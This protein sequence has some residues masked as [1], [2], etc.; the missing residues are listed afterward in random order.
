MDYKA[1]LGL[2]ILEWD[3]GS[4]ESTVVWG[5][6]EKVST[7]EVG[8]WVCLLLNLFS[9]YQT[10]GKNRT[11]Q[12]AEMV[13]VDFERS[14]DPHSYLFGIYSFWYFLLSDPIIINLLK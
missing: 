12:S 2:N 6:S 3:L 9:D 10:T 7:A 8:E 14:Y 13:R 11:V 4:E 1:L 5:E